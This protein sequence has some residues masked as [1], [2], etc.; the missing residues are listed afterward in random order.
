[1]DLPTLGSPTI[2]MV[3]ATQESLDGPSDTVRP[4]GLP[5]RDQAAGSTTYFPAVLLTRTEARRSRHEV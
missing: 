2:P 5:R 1:M 4:D 3:S